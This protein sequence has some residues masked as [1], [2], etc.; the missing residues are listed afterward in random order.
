M[1]SS[2][3]RLLASASLLQQLAG[4]RRDAVIPLWL[5][6]CAGTTSPLVIFYVSRYCQP[7]SGYS[8]IDF[9]K[10]YFVSLKSSFIFSGTISLVGPQKC[11]S[12]AD[13]QLVCAKYFRCV[14][15]WDG[16]LGM[17]VNVSHRDAAFVALILAGGW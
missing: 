3:R 6:V 10:L 15:P 9:S 5:C 8:Y 16:G 1:S 12:T 7:P 14:W 4:E 13:N 17:L 11:V 2:S